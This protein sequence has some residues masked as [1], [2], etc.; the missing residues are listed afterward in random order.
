MHNIQNAIIVYLYLFILSA[1]FLTPKER[2]ISSSFF[3]KL[4]LPKRL[5]Y[6]E[7]DLYSATFIVIFLLENSS[8]SKRCFSLLA[9]A[10]SSTI[11]SKVFLP[12][13]IFIFSSSFI[14]EST[15]IIISSLDFKFS[16][17]II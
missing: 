3:V 1:P 6:K 8:I 15:S 2:D 7:M 12:F 4:L 13:P 17:L 9:S 5:T 16:L 14:L 11:I 10:I